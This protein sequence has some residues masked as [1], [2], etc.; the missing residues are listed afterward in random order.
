MTIDGD[1]SSAPTHCK[2]MVDPVKAYPHFPNSPFPANNLDWLFS[3]T[4][5]VMI[6]IQRPDDITRSDQKS[7]MPRHPHTFRPPRPAKPAQPT[8]TRCYGPFRLRPA[9]FRAPHLPH[10]NYRGPQRKNSGNLP[11]SG[12]SQNLL[13]RVW[14]VEC[15]RLGVDRSPSKSDGWLQPPSSDQRSVRHP[16]V[17]PSPSRHHRPCRRRGNHRRLG[18]RPSADGGLCRS[19]L[20]RPGSGRPG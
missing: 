6:G 15:P 8:P 20:Q 12:R 5:P 3:V 4:S 16:Q 17:G 10:G 11:S 19:L 1:Y 13:V 14:P 7:L 2:K 18:W 9:P